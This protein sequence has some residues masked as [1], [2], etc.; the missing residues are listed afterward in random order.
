MNKLLAL[1]LILF[2]VGHGFAS[3]SFAD[4][5]VESFWG[6]IAKRATGLSPVFYQYERGPK[7]AVSSYKK[8][9]TPEYIRFKCY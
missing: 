9:G 2:F 5:Y 8:L 7:H 6:S 1:K 3:A 4:A